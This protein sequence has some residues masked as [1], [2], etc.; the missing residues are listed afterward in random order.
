MIKAPTLPSY[1]VHA[2]QNSDLEPSEEGAS[3][4]KS[5]QVGR[6]FVRHNADESRLQILCPDFLGTP[7]GLL[8][9]TAKKQAPYDHDR[10]AC[11]CLSQQNGSPMSGMELFTCTYGRTFALSPRSV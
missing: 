11:T 5:A 4:P 7:V 10:S 2:C 3:R 9:E 6:G 1:E 8:A